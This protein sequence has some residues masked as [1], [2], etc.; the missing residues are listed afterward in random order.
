MPTQLAAA[1]VCVVRCD[2]GDSASGIPVL[3]KLL[4][5]ARILLPPR[6]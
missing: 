3:E 6:T 2:A 1:A 5:D 4:T